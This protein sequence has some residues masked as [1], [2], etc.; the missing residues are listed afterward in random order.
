VPLKRRQGTAFAGMLMSREQVWTADDLAISR[1]LGGTYA[2]AWRELQPAGTRESIGTHARRW[3]WLAALAAGLALLAPVPMTALAPVEIVA[4]EPSIVAAPIDGVV[5]TIEVAPNEP[6]KVGDVL[7]RFADT[8]LRNRREIAAREVTVAQARVRQLSLMAFGDA[9]GRH[10]LGLAE[11]ELELK[12]A[13]LDFAD[14]LLARSTVRA[15]RDGIAIYP[16][17][18]SLIGKPVSTGERLMEIAEPSQV[19]ARIDGAIVDAIALRQDGRAKLFLDVDP[20]HPWN[21]R[22][23]RADYKARPSDTDVL[24]FRAIAT[25]E[26]GDAGLPRLGLRGTA[27]I[28]GDLTPLALVLFRRPITAARQWLGL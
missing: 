22:I 24:A 16:D 27:Q 11:A 23:V 2:H 7:V 12:R 13:E 20:L 14:A 10:E 1:R 5:D 25:L 19:E 18:K 6:V 21:G 26:P 3:R 15:L 9:K 8:T 28:Y 17:R 4:R